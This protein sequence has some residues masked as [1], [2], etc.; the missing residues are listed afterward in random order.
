M[1]RTE[2]EGVFLQNVIA[3]PHGSEDGSMKV[4][5]CELGDE[6]L[7]TQYTLKMNVYPHAS[8]RTFTC[9]FLLPRD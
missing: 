6:Y 9:D 1:V 2:G 7:L 3:W 5:W 8:S 4:E